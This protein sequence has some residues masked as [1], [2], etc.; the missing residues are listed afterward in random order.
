M[1][2]AIEAL[3]V[4]MR[5]PSGITALSNLSFKVY[6]NEITALIG[7]NGAGKT[8]TLKIIM[9]FLT[10]TS[11]SVSVC[12]VSP[13]D[14][15]AFLSVKRKIAFVPQDNAFDYFLSLWDNL[16][17]FL[18]MYGFPKKERE[19]R[20][21]RVLKEFNLWEKRKEPIEKLSGGLVRRGQLARAFAI[22]PEILILDEPTVG[23]DP[24]SRRDFWDL[25]RDFMK[26]TQRAVLWT[27]HYME[28]VEENADKVVLIN[29]GKKI[30]EGPPKKIRRMF[31]ENIVIVE[32]DE[33]RL[34]DQAADIL[35]G[36]KVSDTTVIVRL[37]D[38]GEIQEVFRILANSGLR[39]YRVTL[40][41]KDLED[42]YLEVIG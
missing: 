21:V 36:K 5:Y 10:P 13:T 38:E 7:P 4:T 6:R 41:V 9:G 23:L 33:K 20:I 37:S 31:S 15:R 3:N 1:N 39:P 8:T 2:T 22:D 24:Q 30:L 25:V 35:N 29:H 17:I 32:F 12:G 19:D 42:I 11:G 40:G 27:T 34:A 16:D 14:E 18:R 28:E 26:T